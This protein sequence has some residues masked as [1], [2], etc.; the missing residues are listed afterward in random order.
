MQKAAGCLVFIHFWIIPLLL[1]D[2]VVDYSMK[3]ILQE[4]VQQLQAEIQVTLK[5]YSA[6][7][8]IEFIL[9]SAFKLDQIKAEDDTWISNKKKEIPYIGE[10]RSIQM[11]RSSTGS[12]SPGFSIKYQ[13]KLDTLTCNRQLINFN[14]EAF[15]YPFIN[16]FSGFIPLTSYQ[17]DLETKNNFQLIVP[18]GTVKARGN[19]YDI[20]IGPGLHLLQ[21]YGSDNISSLILQEDGLKIRYQKLNTTLTNEDTLL[22]QSVLDMLKF[23]HSTFARNDSIHD[24]HFIRHPYPGNSYAFNGGFI[25]R[26]EGFKQKA[27]FHRYLAHEV[28]HSWWKHGSN[29][30]FNRWLNESFAEYSGHLYVKEKLGEPA[31]EE[32]MDQRIRNSYDSGPIYDTEKF[33]DYAIMYDK[34]TYRLYQLHQKLG[35]QKFQKLLRQVVD[36]KVET[37]EEILHIIEQVGDQEMAEWF[38]AKLKL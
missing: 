26:E 28:S 32:L 3:I 30:N 23:F 7:D 15:W 18:E 17:V 37:T 14:N 12:L 11:A 24:F 2:P 33:Y 16:P 31:F 19:K 13:G 6:S 35:D 25:F 5:N 4:N 34:G 20:S 9:P 38:L 22:A 10:V 27:S 36:E 1:A 8:T 21:I 29:A